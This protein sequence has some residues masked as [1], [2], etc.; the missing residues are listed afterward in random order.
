M[1]EPRRL[2]SDIHQS[3]EPGGVLISVT[4]N[5][6]S[7]LARILGRRFPPYCLQHPQ[8]Y[9]PQSIR[10]LYE[11]AGFEVVEIVKTR[12]YFP[13]SF[14]INAGLKVIGV[15]WEPA[16]N[17]LSRIVGVSVGNIAVVARKPQ[18]RQK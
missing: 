10:L 4:H 15:R 7:W 17:L 12:N 9:S 5:V 1:L 11:R 13:I 2:L 16:G 8:L 18:G 3:L 6:A 14:W